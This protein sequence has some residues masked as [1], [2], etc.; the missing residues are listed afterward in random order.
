MHRLFRKEL[1]MTI[2][3]VRVLA[4]SHMKEHP[5]MRRTY[6]VVRLETSDGL[7]GYGE[8]SSNYGHSY[9]TVIRAIV[10]DVLAR[11]LVGRNA[12]DIETRVAEMHGL[13][14][15][16][17]GWEGVTNQAIGAVEIALWDLLGKQ[18]GL[19][20]ARLL[21]G[22]PAPLKLYATGTTMFDSSPEWYAAYF[23]PALA[24]G[25]TG[26][27]ARIG[28]DANAAIAR[29]AGLREAVGPDIDLMVDAYWGYS[30]EEARALADR[31]S[32]YDIR[33][34]EEPSPQTGPG[35]DSL[36]ASF[37]MPIAVGERVYSPWQFERI[38][39]QGTAHVLEPDASICGGI[40]ACMKVAATA[41]AHGL[42]LVPHLGSPT[43][44]GLA[45]NLQWASAAR[46]DL[47]EFDVYPHLPMRDELMAEPVFALDRVVDGH[48]HVPDGPGL[49][50]EIDEA[51]L[52]RF[53]Y[54][55]GGT[56][57]EVFTEH[58]RPDSR[59]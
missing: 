40:L 38:A 26:L 29:V 17:L 53:P 34:F 32:A 37:P 24:R 57:A 58:E 8:A 20:I 27:K 22:A 28:T 2:S 15:G 44:I 11:S 54:E 39:E 42:G 12:R 46:C 14:D 36:A 31:L 13:L 16:Y 21:G 35:F 3:D 52:K 25:I 43:A 50:I 6:A 33:F 59:R 48:V 49:G 45:A 51:A 30:V 4:L 18:E 47:V 23:A 1:S 10:E 56:F 41:R 19:S 5:P 9:P 7:V 55:F